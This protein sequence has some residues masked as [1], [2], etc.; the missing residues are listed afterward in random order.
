VQ[1]EGSGGISQHNNGKG[2]TLRNSVKIIEVDVPGGTG[3]FCRKGVCFVRGDSGDGKK[4]NRESA[5]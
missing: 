4:G 2:T 1:K 3:L 5:T